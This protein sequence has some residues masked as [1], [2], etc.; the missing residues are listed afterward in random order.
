ME[1]FIVTSSD[2]EGGGEGPIIGVFSSEAL[3]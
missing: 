3:A 2:S 1:L